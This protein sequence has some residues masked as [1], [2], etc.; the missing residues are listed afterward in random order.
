MSTKRQL[1][2]K[3]GRTDHNR[4]R[5]MW[6]AGIG[7]GSAGE[8]DIKKLRREARAKLKCAAKG[9]GNAGRG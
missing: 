2:L 7:S 9:T 3:L 5:K 8:L 6:A 4:P 1:K